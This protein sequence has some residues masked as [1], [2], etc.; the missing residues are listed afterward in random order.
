MNEE[1]E[2]TSWTLPE[3]LSESDIADYISSSGSSSDS[4]SD[5]D[6]AAAAAPAAC[7][8]MRCTHD[9]GRT[10]YMNEATE[11]TSWTLP[12]GFT[13]AQ[14]ADFVSESESGSD[15]DSD[16]GA[17]AS[18]PCPWMRCTHDDGRTY[19]M[20]EATEKTSWTL[21]SGYTDAQIEDFVSESESDDSDEEGDAPAAPAARVAADEDGGA[22]PPP[23]P[24]AGKKKKA[25]GAWEASDSGSG[26]DD[27]WGT[28]SGGKTSGTIDGVVG[29]DSAR[30]ASNADEAAQDMA[31]QKARI[32]MGE[33]EVKRQA[34]K[35]RAA[36]AIAKA[37]QAAADGGKKMKTKKKKKKKKLAAPP[38]S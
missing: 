33:A 4:D 31:R 36:K 16:D 25:K 30:L 38:P 21:P 1:T 17:A 7:P 6:V 23:P 20:N 13:D 5:E 28:G 18:G 27:D 9:D 11:K 35:K 12:G 22:P 29:D 8:W 32:A 3:G 24:S 37:K 19:Y 14:I 34:A 10:Y 2:T 26:S 15:S